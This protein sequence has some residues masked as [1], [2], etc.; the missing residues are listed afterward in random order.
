MVPIQGLRFVVLCADG[1]DP[2]ILDMR[3]LPTQVAQNEQAEGAKDSANPFGLFEPRTNIQASC[4]SFLSDAGGCADA[5]GQYG[6]ASVSCDRLSGTWAATHLVRGTTPGTWAGTW[7]GTS[8]RCFPLQDVPFRLDIVNDPVAYSQFRSW[9]APHLATT[10]TWGLPRTWLLSSVSVNI[11][12]V[13]NA[14]VACPAGYGTCVNVFGGIRSSIDDAP[15][16]PS[17]G[18]AA[19]AFAR[20]ACRQFG[21]TS[22][23]VVM[24]CGSIGHLL[25]AIHER[26][27]ETV[28]PDELRQSLVRLC[29]AKHGNASSPR[30]DLDAADKMSASLFVSGDGDDP[31]AAQ[32]RLWQDTRSP[33][34]HV[35]SRGSRASLSLRGALA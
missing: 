11:N 13:W 24:T 22:A 26:G 31:H 30:I 1:G 20:V 7:A 5:R 32:A 35:F 27:G 33:V 18:R 2:W 28:L 19:A 15:G 4:C 12:G 9:V 8:S 3:R 17:G 25:R 6:I 10:N 34:R 16:S 29:G 14:M 23:P 21:F